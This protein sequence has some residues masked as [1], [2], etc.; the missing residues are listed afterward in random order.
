[1]QGPSMGGIPPGGGM[2]QT[3]NVAK[4]P[5]Q[6][7]ISSAQGKI[8]VYPVTGL[9][10]VFVV[11]VKMDGNDPGRKYRVALASTTGQKLSHKDAIER[12]TKDIDKVAILAECYLA[13]DVKSVSYDTTS[14]KVTRDF[15]NPTRHKSKDALIAFQEPNEEEEGEEIQVTTTY[16]SQAKPK[17]ERHLEEFLKHKL[18]SKNQKITHLKTH[19]QQG[20]SFGQDIANLP[21]QSKEYYVERIQRIKNAWLLYKA[22]DLYPQHPRQRQVGEGSSRQEEPIQGTSRG[23]EM[24]VGPTP[25]PLL[26]TKR[27]QEFYTPTDNTPVGSPLGSRR[28]MPQE[29]LGQTQQ[30]VFQGIGIQSPNVSAFIG[31]FPFVNP[32]GSVGVNEGELS[33]DDDDEIL[34]EK[35]QKTQKNPPGEETTPTL[36]VQ[37]A[38]ESKKLSDAATENQET[39]QQTPPKGVFNQ[40]VTLEEM[41]D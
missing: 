15:A 35:K 25:P 14:G 23:E 28:G 10:H 6:P 8:N 36:P 39:S 24:P 16:P 32:E 18:L 30:N 7:I 34:L 17:P 4:P 41:D 29:N 11:E 21:G 38:D 31:D 40:D 1:M 20:A 5:A 12:L 19:E 9:P 37:E 2:P 22:S 26:P 33:D 3:P 13:S 27:E